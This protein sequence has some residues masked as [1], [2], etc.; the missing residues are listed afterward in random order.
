MNKAYFEIKDR[1]RKGLLKYLEKAVSIIPKIEH[2]EILDMGCGTGVPT[3]FLL[4]KFNGNITAI[5]FDAKSLNRL[6]EKVKELN[7]CKSVSILNSSFF[8]MNVENNSFDLI[9]AEGFLN[10]VGFEKGF[11]KMLKLLKRNGFFIIHDEFKNQ[12]SKTECIERNNCRI[13]DSFRLNEQV[14]WDDYYQCLEKEI[15]SNRDKAVSKLFESDL[16]EINLFKKDPSRF[17][18]IYL[19]IRKL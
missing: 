3:L 15:K 16:Q 7:L 17:N 19:I 2:L 18:S 4:E 1:C 5:D 12:H 11:L 6:E 13:V 8:E 9:I 14:W 10:V